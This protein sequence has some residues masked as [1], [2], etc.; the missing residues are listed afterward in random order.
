MAKMIV[1]A[2]KLTKDIDSIKIAYEKN[3]RLFIRSGADG[4]V[5]GQPCQSP[6]RGL[7]KWGFKTVEPNP[8]FRDSEEII[9]N[10]DRFSMKSDGTVQYH[11]Y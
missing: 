3:G 5:V 10:L 6:L 7:G 2:I 9:D 4:F 1:V 11:E 8:E